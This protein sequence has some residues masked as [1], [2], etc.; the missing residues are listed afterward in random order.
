MLVLGINARRG[1]VACGRLGV[2]PRP[3]VG[4]EYTYVCAKVYMYVF[5]LCGGAEWTLGLCV[6]FKIICFKPNRL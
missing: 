5:V 3:R 4:L 2:E 1:Y 6:V